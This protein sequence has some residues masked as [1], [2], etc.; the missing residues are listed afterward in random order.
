MSQAGPKP[1]EYYVERQLLTRLPATPALPTDRSSNYS[2]GQV[3]PPQGSPV[4]GDGLVIAGV[5]AIVVSVYP[6]ENQTFSGA[7]SLL[8]WVYNPYQAYWT[9][10][11]DLDLDLTDATGFRAKTFAA[12]QNISRLGML[13]NWLASAV[14]TTGGTDILVRIDGFT[15]S[16]NSL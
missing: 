12:F 16:R 15:S 7:G 13:I 2:T 5:M 4:A 6:W 3:I 9:R 1:S 10:A 14:T 8:C 11:S